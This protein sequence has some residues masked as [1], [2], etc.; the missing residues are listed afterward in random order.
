MFRRKLGD[1]FGDFDP[2]HVNIVVVSDTAGLKWTMCVTAGG[3]I[4]LRGDEKGG[5]ER[6]H[7]RVEECCGEACWIALIAMAEISDMSKALMHMLAVLHQI[8]CSDQSRTVA[9]C[10]MEM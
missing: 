5:E 8:N 10:E 1:K 6:A 4:I 7:L 9:R 2:A 3:E